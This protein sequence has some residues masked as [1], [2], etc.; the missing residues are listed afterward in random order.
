MDLASTNLILPKNNNYD[1]DLLY[2][3]LFNPYDGLNNDMKH[4][5]TNLH[6]SD[7]EV[8]YK[9]LYLLFY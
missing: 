6:L 2:D 3:N 7:V 4:R 5:L 8:N 1:Y 9:D